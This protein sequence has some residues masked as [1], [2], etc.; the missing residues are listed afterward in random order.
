MV[1]IEANTCLQ[2]VHSDIHL[3]CFHDQ[4]E[5][6]CHASH[7]LPQMATMILTSLPAFSTTLVNLMCVINLFSQHPV[8]LDG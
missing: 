4:P 3:P 6:L 2:I 5:T 7:N 1:L 8:N